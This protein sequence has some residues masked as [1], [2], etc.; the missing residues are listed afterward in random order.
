MLIGL[1]LPWLSAR[2]KKI[3]IFHDQYACNSSLQDFFLVQYQAKG[4]FFK[5]LAMFLWFRNA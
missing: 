2:L 4:G 5:Y 3:C 1:N